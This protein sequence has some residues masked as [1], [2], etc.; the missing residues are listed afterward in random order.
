MVGGGEYEGIEEEPAEALGADGGLG[1]GFVFFFG[2]EDA[3]HPGRHEAQQQGGGGV[4]A[5]CVGEH[6]DKEAEGKGEQ[7]AKP[8]GGIEGEQEDEDYVD[9]RCDEG[10]DLNVVED[11]D[12]QKHEEEEADDIAE[13]VIVH[14]E[15]VFRVR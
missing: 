14:P 11:Q 3:L 13:Y 10:K 6:I 2:A 4:D 15:R 5:A 9:V 12:L 1:T 7:E 8:T